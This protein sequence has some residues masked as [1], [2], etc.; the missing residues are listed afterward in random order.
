MTSNFDDDERALSRALHGRVDHLTESPLGLD[1]VQ[2][3]ARVVRRRRQL[4]AGAALAVAV[5]VIVPTAVVATRGLDGGHGPRAGHRERHQHAHRGERESRAEPTTPA[6]PRPSDA[7][8]RHRS[9]LPDRRRPEDRLG[10]GRDVHRAD[11]SV[12]RRRAARGHDGLAPDGRRLGGRHPRRRGQRLRA[13]HPGRRHVRAGALRASTATS[14]PRRWA[15]SSRG[16]SPTGSVNG[17]AGRRRDTFEMAPITAAGPYDAVAV[18]TEDCQ[19]GAHDGRRLHRLRQHPGRAAAGL[20]H[21]LARHRR[22]AS[23]SDIDEL[24]AWSDGALRRHHR[25]STTT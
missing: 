2:G 15:R 12:G 11:G 8:V 24:T 6:E 23:T 20:V 3:K 7:A 16:P 22:P 17:H 14:P 18:D 1:D 4:A 5:A 19:E 21:H 10:R 13:V 25:A 9:D